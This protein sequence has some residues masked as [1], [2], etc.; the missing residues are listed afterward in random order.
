MAKNRNEYLIID[1]EMTCESPRPKGYS[2]EVIEIGIVHMTFD[3]EI[4]SKEQIIVN[5]K[6]NEVS[7]FCTELT[8]Y[9]KE[10]LKKHGVPFQD[11]C[12][13]LLK[14]GSKNKAVI[15]WGEDW[16][17]F[18]LECEL[19]NIE[20][21]LSEHRVNLSLVHSMLMKTKEKVSLEDAIEYWGIERSGELH[22]GVDDAYHT[23]LIFKKLIDK[24]P[25]F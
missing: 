20:N 16:K 17:Q 2:P 15:A 25:K 11:A 12:R 18:E 8:G 13:K 22:R 10:Y 5:P 1:L 19:K 14:M 6:N 23:A 21:P 7:E 4:K 24:F 9:T 3:G